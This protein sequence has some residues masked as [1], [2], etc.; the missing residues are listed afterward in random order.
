MSAKFPIQSNTL[1][2]AREGNFWLV[3][4]TPIAFGDTESNEKRPIKQSE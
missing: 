1:Y 2:I 4:V 3:H